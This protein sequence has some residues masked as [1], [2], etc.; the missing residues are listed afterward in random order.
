[1]STVIEVHKGCSAIIEMNEGTD[2]IAMNVVKDGFT[3]TIPNCDVMGKGGNTN[4]LAIQQITTEGSKVVN[5]LQ[6]V[7][8]MDESDRQFIKYSIEA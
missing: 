5:F 7:F 2:L 6:E 1:M 4:R 8:C 3:I